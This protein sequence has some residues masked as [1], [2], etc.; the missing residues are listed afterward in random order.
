MADYTYEAEAIRQGVSAGSLV[1]HGR[2][3]PV[4]DPQSPESASG[5]QSRVCATCRGVPVVR[6]D[7]GAGSA[8]IAPDEPGG[9][10]PPIAAS[11]STPLRRGRAAPPRGPA[12]RS[13]P[14]RWTSWPRPRRDARDRCRGRPGRAVSA[15]SGMIAAAVGVD[16][17]VE[18]A[19]GQ[20]EPAAT[21]PVRAAQPGG[22]S[23]PL[24]TRSRRVSTPM[25]Q[26]QPRGCADVHPLHRRHARPRETCQ[27]AGVRRGESPPSGARAGAAPLRP[28]IRRPDAVLCLDLSSLYRRSETASS[29]TPE[30]FDP[31]PSLTGT[32]RW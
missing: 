17:P 9:E 19:A 28:A 32:V 11:R 31:S 4:A 12:D 22:T 21:D 15:V 24:R 5:I 20:A 7:G 26:P 6:A 27:M 29:A 14:R 1:N 23:L 16:A 8:W 25:A 3:G 10:L 13:R 30:A 18:E 2:G